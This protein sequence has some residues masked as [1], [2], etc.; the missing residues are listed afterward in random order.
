[1]AYLVNFNGNNLEQIVGISKV[2]RDILPERQNYSKE[3]PSLNGSYYT[4]YK[5]KERN[6]SIDIYIPSKT[7]EERLETVR[8]L[9]KV[10]DTPAPA[11]LIIDDEPDKFCYAVLDGS[12]NLDTL[13]T[14][15]TATLDF[16]CY[17]PYLY[18]LKDKSFEADPSSKIVT[19]Q[20]EGGTDTF[21][22]MSINFF[23]PACFFQATNLSGE[24]ILVGSRPDIE[25]PTTVA[26]TVSL[27]DD[28]T[29]TSEWQ[30]SGNVTD[31][32]RLVEGS[33]SVGMNGSAIICNNFGTTNDQQWHGCGIRRNIGA[34]IEEFEVKAKM[35]F[36]STGKN[37]TT[38]GSSSGGSTSLG[39]Y[40]V[41]N[42][43]E[44]L[45]IRQTGSTSAK[46]LGKLSNGQV[47]SPTEIKNGWAKHTTGGITGWSSMTYLSKV[48]SNNT[49]T[50]I[51]NISKYN[52]NI[53]SSSS[54]KGKVLGTLKPSAT[55]PYV[56]TAST[57]WYKVTYKGKDA[58]VTNDKTLTSKA[59]V[60]TRATGGDNPVYAED[61]LGLMELYGFD[62]N[63]QKLFKF[64]IKDSEEF[65]EFTQPEVYI[66]TNNVLKD[67]KKVPAPNIVKEYDD[68]GKLKEEKTVAS[69]VYGSWNDFEGT[70]T[71]KRTKNSK[72][73]FTWTAKVEKVVNGKITATLSTSNSLVNSNYPNGNLNHVV[74]FIGK[75]QNHEAVKEMGLTELSVQQLNK[76][77]IE[78]QNVQI[79]KAGDILKIDS[80]SG[81]V[82]LNGES[83]LEELD[84][85]TQFFSVPAGKSQF[86][87]N[88]DDDTMNVLVGVK[89]R[90]L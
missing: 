54:T 22:T 35:I 2:K 82:L 8:E 76:V 1:M 39:S 50:V 6:I 9:A 24:T 36:S 28:C 14:T 57:G 20:N 75:Y 47:I 51:K 19:I 64:L 5:Y 89:E 77:D 53:R 7:R 29:T 31:S 79:F 18:A 10:L 74:L 25:K 70:F 17:D 63:G 4:G 30:T 46:I 83:F 43:K 42:A 16:V 87:V 32:G 44:G 88:S 40:K 34:N 38:G 66:G 68:D 13:V 73:D 69:G 41:I 23:K 26:T 49:K 90:W 37:N 72:G 61:Q 11:V 85:G 81:E 21:P 52:V 15:G 3:V 80:E 62:Q 67:S 60:S 65:F 78:E 59:T 86:I 71:I 58:Y 27:K 55:L 12:T 48:T 33:A 45:R 84:I 56:S